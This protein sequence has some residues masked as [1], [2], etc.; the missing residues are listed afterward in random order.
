MALLKSF[1]YEKVQFVGGVLAGKQ[2]IEIPATPRMRAFSN[3]FFCTFDHYV[4]AENHTNCRNKH[5][6]P[7]RFNFKKDIEPLE[8]EVIYYCSGGNNTFSLLNYLHTLFRLYL[9]GECPDWWHYESYLA[10]LKTN[11][12]AILETKE[13]LKKCG[14]DKL[15]QWNWLRSTTEQ[16]M[17]LDEEID[18]DLAEPVA[19]AQSRNDTSNATWG[20]WTPVYGTS[21][22]G[23]Y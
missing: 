22:G 3:T 15:M 1:E 11:E 10:F 4:V 21:T 5:I 14:F 7:I 20:T 16:N 12:S 17:S 6:I 13:Y 9:E 19:T 23:N 2:W 8:L 18:I